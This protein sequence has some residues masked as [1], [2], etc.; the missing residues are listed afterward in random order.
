MARQAVGLT[1]NTDWI[2]AADNPKRKHL[3]N[4]RAQRH[5]VQTGQSN[6]RPVI[7]GAEL[8]QLGLRALV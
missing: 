4:V 3:N 1:P 8:C 2:P 7:E 6:T 5:F